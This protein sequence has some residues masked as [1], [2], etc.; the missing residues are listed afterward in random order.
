MGSQKKSTAPS[1]KPKAASVDGA[2][3]EEVDIAG[4]NERDTFVRRI[5][6]LTAENARLTQEVSARDGFLAV[7]AH[8]LKN[9]LTPVI[10][11]VDLVRRRLPNWPPEKVQSNLVQI[12]QAAQ[13][14]ARRATTLLD[15]SRMTSGKLKLDC[16]KVKVVPVIRSIVESY[17]LLA[18]R[19]RC[20]LTLDL[21][22]TDLAIIG[23]QLALEQILDN[24]ISNAIK[25]GGG[26]SITVSARATS[27][28]ARLSVSDEGPGISPEARARIFERFERAVR[29]GQNA[30][31]FGIGLWVVKQLSDAMDG[32]VDVTSSPGAGSTF[33]ITLP[34]C[35]TKDPE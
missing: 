22:E 28:M 20:E 18:E 34:L 2:V 29:S 15:V 9:A 17:R 12:E 16:C 14:F 1:S 30:A 21:P 10:A 19:A 32:V 27:G 31:G 25:Y 11:R 3:S 23:D 35:Q 33:H 13:M 26:T 6:E 24:L 8:E 4:E 5:A 7:A